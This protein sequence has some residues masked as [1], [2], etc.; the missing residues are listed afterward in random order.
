M[1]EKY[2]LLLI[3]VQS[4]KNASIGESQPKR[5]ICQL[6]TMAL[7]NERRAKYFGMIITPDARAFEIIFNERLDLQHIFGFRY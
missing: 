5:D 7:A 6:F 2:V 3:Y 1:N 4:K